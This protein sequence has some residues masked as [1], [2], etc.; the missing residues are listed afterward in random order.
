MLFKV[1][2]N[3]SCR[4]KTVWSDIAL[5]KVWL[6]LATQTT[7]SGKVYWLTSYLGKHCGHGLK[8]RWLSVGNWKANSV[9]SCQTLTCCW[10]IHPPSV[11]PVALSPDFLLC[12]WQSGIIIIM[13]TRGI[14]HLNNYS[15]FVFLV[16][17]WNN[18][19]CCHVVILR[20]TWKC[21]QNSGSL[22][23]RLK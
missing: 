16:F 18:R 23:F 6:G 11:H 13:A 21:H 1:V 19:C 8:E 22:F 7:W 20:L 9:L 15:M 10:P 2:T 5:I 12:S 3:Y 4:N 14:C 17:C